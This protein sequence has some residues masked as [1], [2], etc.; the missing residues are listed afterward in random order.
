MRKHSVHLYFLAVS[1][2]L[3]FQIGCQKHISVVSAAEPMVG[4]A[5]AE[6][7]AQPTEP[8]PRIEF[9]ALVHDFGQ[10]GPNTKHSYKFKFTNTGSSLLKIGKVQTTCGCT[11]AKLRKKEYAPGES[12]ELGVTYSAESQAR[13]TSKHLYVP[14]ND[15][16]NPKIELTIKAQ[17][18]LQVVH[19]PQRLNLILKKENAGC[20]AITL[21][22]LDNK[23]FA[24]TS[25][26]SKPPCIKADFDTALTATEFVLQ[27]TVD[28]EQLQKYLAGSISIG[29]T[30]PECKMVSIHFNAQPEFKTTP[31]MITAFNAEPE[32][33]IRREL[34]LLNSY[35]DGFEI[36]SV[37]SRNGIIKLL[38]QKSV[39]DKDGVNNRYKLEVEIV[40]PVVEA[41]NFSDVLTVNIKGGGQVNVNCRG[42]YA[43]KK[44]SF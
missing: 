11:I 1:I 18:V 13:S 4:T 16:T 23:E 5:E 14:S 7:T 27:P 42:F 9:E 37:S 36:E 38:S 26:R 22:S 33:A 10:I 25:F 41:K 3:L 24:I 29:L 44:T 21:R 12:G 30:H 31:A 35:G 34:W 6:S 39:A 28:I 15:K 19:E 43:R 17:V 2:F 20:P 32:K 40:P 8:G